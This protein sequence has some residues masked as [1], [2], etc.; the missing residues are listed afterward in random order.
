LED[1]DGASADLS[2]GQPVTVVVERRLGSMFDGVDF[3]AADAQAQAEAVLAAI[4]ETTVVR[5]AA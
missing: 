5:V 1:G 4:T 3:A 2:P